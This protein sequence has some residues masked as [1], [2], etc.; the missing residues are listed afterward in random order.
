MYGEI[1]ARSENLV[2]NGVIRCRSGER[3]NVTLQMRLVSAYG[4]LTG[5]LAGKTESA[6][7]GLSCKYL[8]VQRL[9]VQRSVPNRRRVGPA[10]D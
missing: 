10:L 5:P 9:C 8:E 7:K 2:K 1:G 6:V 4:R 3:V